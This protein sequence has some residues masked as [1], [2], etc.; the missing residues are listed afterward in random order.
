[1]EAEGLDMLLMREGARMDEV[2]GGF[3]II[4]VSARTRNFV[5]QLVERRCRVAILRA[6][7]KGAEDVRSVSP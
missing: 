2:N 3:Y 5:S 4:R 6:G 1:M 7:R